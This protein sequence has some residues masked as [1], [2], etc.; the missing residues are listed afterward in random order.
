MANE[1]LTTKWRTARPPKRVTTAVMKPASCMAMASIMGKSP[2]RLEVLVLPDRVT[3]HAGRT[4]NYIPI[5]PNDNI[6]IVFRNFTVNLDFNRLLR[7]MMRMTSSARR[8]TSRSTLCRPQWK[9]TLH[10]ESF[11]CRAAEVLEL[12][13][14]TVNGL[15]WAAVSLPTLASRPGGL[16]P[17]RGSQRGRRS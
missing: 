9:G 13:W 3:K 7:Q 12:P 17:R 14:S 16:L 5:M 1:M 15:R 2:R 4:N 11:C 10:P 8:R 6:N